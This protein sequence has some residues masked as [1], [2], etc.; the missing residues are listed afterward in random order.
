MTVPPGSG[1]PVILVVDDDEDVRET[2][3]LILGTRGFEVLVAA[4]TTEAMTICHAR[5]GRV[6]ALIADLSLPGEGTGE[7][8]RSVNAAY[9]AIRMIYA[10][11]IP[12]HVAMNLGLVQPGIPY[13]EKPLSGDGLVNV[14]QSVLPRRRS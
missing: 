6:D 12:R 3:S 14:L 8:A 1:P 4:S 11:G 13:L 5:Q 7:L 10:T 9:P 2:T